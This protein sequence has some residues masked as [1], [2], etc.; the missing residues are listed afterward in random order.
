MEAGQPRTAGL[1]TKQAIIDQPYI[2]GYSLM[3]VDKS[4]LRCRSPWLSPMRNYWKLYQL[5]KPFAE[6]SYIDAHKMLV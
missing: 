4:R 3:N 6:L 2:R 1:R 5:G